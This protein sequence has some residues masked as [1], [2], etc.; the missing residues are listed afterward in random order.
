MRAS[1]ECADLSALWSRAEHAFRVGTKAVTSH[2]TP[3]RRLDQNSRKYSHD[4]FS[5]DLSALW[6]RA[7]H[8]IPSWVQGGVRF[9]TVCRLVNK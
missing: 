1:L 3:R 7:E 4:A 2:R 5:A 8:C 9:E 6:S